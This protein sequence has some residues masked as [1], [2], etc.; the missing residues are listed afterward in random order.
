MNMDRVLGIVC[1]VCY[2]RK[3]ETLLKF[4][5]EP[6]EPMAPVDCTR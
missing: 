5:F 2:A 6:E 1:Y 3:Q 4:V